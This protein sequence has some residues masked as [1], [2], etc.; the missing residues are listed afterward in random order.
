MKRVGETGFFRHLL[1]QG[2]G[3]LQAFGGVVHLEPDQILIWALVVMA[4]EQAAQIGVVDMALGGDLF[5]R[6]QPQ[7][8]ILDMLA[9]LL[10]G[11]KG[12][13]FQAF[14]WCSCPGNPQGQTLQ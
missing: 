5:Q 3:L 12:V 7:A 14:D 11:G 8:M 2:T 4:S 1:H 6:P 9:A 10:E 13:G